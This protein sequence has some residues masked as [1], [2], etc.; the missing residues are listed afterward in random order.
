MIGKKVENFLHQKK[1][2]IENSRVL[3][4]VSGGPDSLALLHL[5]WKNQKKWNIE[6]FAAHV[7]HMFRGEESYE[8]ALFVQEFCKIRNIAFEM[9]Q[10]DVPQ[11]ME[12]T[13]LSS[14]VAARECRYQFFA[15]VFVNN[16]I[17]YLALGHHG[18][19]QV[20]TILMRLTRGSTGKA[21]AGIPFARTFNTGYIFRPF[22]C[23]SRVEIEAYCTYYELNPR[24]DPSNDTLEYSRNRFRHQVLP[25]LHQ[26]NPQVHLQF[27]RFSDELSSDEDF[28]QQLSIQE[29]SKVMKV[30]EQGKI[31]IGIKDFLA[32]PMPLQ[33]RGIQLI[34]KYLYKEKPA[35]LS[36]IHIDQVFVLIT[37]P[38]PSGILD[39][40]NGLKIVRS[41]DEC[42]FLFGLQEAEPYRIEISKA[43][44]YLL[45][46]GARFE[47]VY[48]DE[49]CDDKDLYTLKLNLE[50][51]LPII[52]RS[53]EK[54]DRMTL[55]GMTG[56]K[57]L[58]NLFI[59][60]KVPVQERNSWPV[61]TDYSNQILWIPGL[62]KANH[63]FVGNSSNRY[64]R[65]KYIK[66]GSSRGAQRNEK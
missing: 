3:V 40:P 48:A 44:S 15:E 53:R 47:M 19:D 59:E 65:L 45:P 27:E 13:G 39:F 26:E 58:K 10:V 42:Q 24:R 35:S 1:F 29:M 66:H 37:N 50:I 4:G 25:F 57:K 33:R 23:L 56:T 11:Y 49:E 2:H 6:I 51:S 34:L 20:E 28:L 41:Y 31:V 12:Q 8:E 43:G 21:R 9:K 46:N 18:D 64:I 61:V 14:E 36:A 7:D 52:I 38:H 16:K 17:D 62:K 30:Q 54:G 60:Q 55:K 5:L 32:L 63:P 22:L